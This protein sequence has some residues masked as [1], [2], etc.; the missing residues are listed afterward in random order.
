[1]ATEE[2]RASSGIMYC[3][4]ADLK[5]EVLVEY[6]RVKQGT[7]PLN[8]KRVLKSIPRK[9]ADK[10]SYTFNDLTYN[11]VYDSTGQ[12][13]VSVTDELYNRVRAFQFLEDAKKKYAQVNRQPAAFLPELRAL[14]D[15]YSDPAMDKLQTLKEGINQVKGAMVEN[16]DKVLER[17][18][19]IDTVLERADELEEKA[20]IFQKRSAELKRRMLCRRI[21]MM[22]CCLLVVLLIVFIIVLFVCSDNG[23]NFDGCFGSKSTPAPRRR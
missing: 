3:A 18:E 9:K 22:M 1:M 17:G 7:I 15:Y 10:G 8:A 12:S 13:L 16:V 19:K 4:V 5:G 11:V 14:A 2:M 23:I 6:C 21:M 20:K